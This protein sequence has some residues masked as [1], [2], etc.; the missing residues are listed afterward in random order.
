MLLFGT[1]EDVDKFSLYFLASNSG[2]GCIGEGYTRNGDN[3][4]III[5][6]NK[7][8]IP[9]DIEYVELNEIFFNQ[10]TVMKLD[11]CTKEIIEKVDESKLKYSA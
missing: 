9:E 10:K 1:V 3:T 7:N 5:Y 8:D 2:L 6:K 11:D 4:V